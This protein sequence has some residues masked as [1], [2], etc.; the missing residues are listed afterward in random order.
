MGRVDQ[1]RMNATTVQNVVTYT[2]IIDFDNPGGR[3][4]PGMTAYVS[5]PVADASSA[6][7]VPNGALRFKPD[8]KPEDIR[9]LYQKYGL[10]RDAGT[11]GGNSGTNAAIATATAMNG[12]PGIG[13]GHGG[14]DSH[15]GGAN[16]QPAGQ[17]GASAA[18]L[19]QAIVWKLGPQQELIPVKI[20]IGI[21]D[22]TLT[23]VSAV[24]GGELTENDDLVTGSM[25]AKGAANPIGGAGARR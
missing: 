14:R 15:G 17:T 21:T 20:R 8:M 25:A 4:F 12:S 3:L 24:L 9:A 1:I 22:H 19:D 23:E 16:G 13:N 6:L 7:R 2:T 18:R 5:V 10:M 11:G